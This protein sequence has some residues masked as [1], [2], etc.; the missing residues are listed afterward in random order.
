MTTETMNMH[1]ALIEKK[2]LPDR[3][4]KAIHDGKFVGVCNKNKNNVDGMSIKEFED[5][6]KASYQKVNDLIKRYFAIKSAIIDSNATTMLEVCGEKMTVADAIDRKNGRVVPLKMLRSVLVAQQTDAM[7]SYMANS[8]AMLEED[9]N[10]YVQKILRSQGGSAEKSDEKF[11]KALHDT[12][13]ENNEF[14]MVDP[15][16][17]KDLIDELDKEISDIESEYDA[18]LSVSNAITNVTF[19]Y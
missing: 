7:M 12:Y 6:A 5:D 11:V 14:K 3:I 19:S 13:I 2:I 18:A 15:L 8:G 16:H 4:N 1:K 9:A 10:D 17:V